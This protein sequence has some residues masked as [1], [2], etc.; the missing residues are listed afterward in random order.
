GMDG[1]HAAD[2]LRRDAKEGELAGDETNPPADVVRTP[3]EFPLPHAV[4]DDNHGIATRDLVLVRSERATQ[5][6]PDAQSGEEIAVDEDADCH[7]RLLFSG[8]R[9]PEQAVLR[10]G[11]SG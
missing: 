5:D 7:P 10:G 4:A 1:C 6:G 3:A 9:E 8:L 11:Q 2:P